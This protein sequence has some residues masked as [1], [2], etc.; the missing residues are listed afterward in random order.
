LKASTKRP[1]GVLLI[2]VAIY[3]LTATKFTPIAKGDVAGAL[4]LATVYLLLFGMIFVGARLARSKD[5]PADRPP[6]A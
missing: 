6:S 1:L 3:T 5:R 4:G 2:V